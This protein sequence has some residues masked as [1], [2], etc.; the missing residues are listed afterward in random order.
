MFVRLPF[1]VSC[2][3]E[4]FGFF[5]TFSQHLFK[6]SYPEAQ[7]QVSKYSTMNER[8]EISHYFNAIS[9]TKRKKKQQQI[10][11]LI[12][13]FLAVSTT[14][15]FA[16]THAQSI[17]HHPNLFLGFN[18]YLSPVFGYG[19]GLPNGAY[20][21]SGL[22]FHTLLDPTN[23]SLNGLL[24]KIHA[25][26]F[27]KKLA[28][29]PGAMSPYYGSF[30]NRL[31]LMK[32]PEYLY[33]PYGLDYGYGK[34]YG[35]AL[36]PNNPYKSP[37]SEYY[38][39]DQNIVGATKVVDKHNYQDAN[40]VAQPSDAAPDSIKAY[41]YIKPMVKIGALLTTAA[42]LGKKTLESPT[43]RLNPAGM[44]LNGRSS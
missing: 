33:T 15:T 22:K 43:I 42:L 11:I 40:L 14:R 18:P 30:K 31:Q 2:P 5:L 37:Y 29:Y 10:K 6:Y 13:L 12:P 36:I 19:L 27:L 8:Q 3:F 38:N 39:N 25:K 4:A 7:H 34:H 9:K 20:G 24:G 26:T 28:T 44:I 41:S 21:Y 16:P 23:V 35:S 17:G 32:H 1:Q